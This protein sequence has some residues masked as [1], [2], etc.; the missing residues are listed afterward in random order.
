M[1]RRTLYL[2][3]FYLVGAA[4]DSHSGPQADS[5]PKSAQVIL[6]I[7]TKQI[8]PFA[9]GDHHLKCTVRNTSD[10]NIRVPTI[11]T[12]GFDADMSLT[13][14]ERHPLNL[15]FWGGPK[16]QEMKALEPGRERL[17]FQDTLQAVLLL[18]FKRVPQSLKPGEARY[19]WNWRA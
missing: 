12:A 19:Y 1:T 5:E 4:G 6:W 13:A 18:D 2:L 8:D 15:V 16:K 7:S 17:I 10:R 11:Y 3:A 14:S 9:P